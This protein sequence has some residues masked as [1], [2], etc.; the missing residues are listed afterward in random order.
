MPNSFFNKH[1]NLYRYI[2]DLAVKYNVAADAI[3]MRFCMDSFPKA[4][5]LS[6]A[7]SANQMR[8]NLLA[9]QIKLQAEDLELLRSYNVNPEM[10]WNERKTLPW[11]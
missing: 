5:C 10:Y 3:A 7:S 2:S 11:Q 9:N 8:S 1:N 4:I 6:G